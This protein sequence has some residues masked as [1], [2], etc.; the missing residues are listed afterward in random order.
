MLK[1]K[2]MMIE[3]ATIDL[4]QTAEA[5]QLKEIITSLNLQRITIQGSNTK[6]FFYKI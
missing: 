1:E 4:H 2:D 6:L 3:L 5:I